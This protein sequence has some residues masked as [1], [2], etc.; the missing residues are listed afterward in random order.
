MKKSVDN[1]LLVEL[2]T[3]IGFILNEKF[4]KLEYGRGSN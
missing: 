2:L 4:N 3:N 1:D